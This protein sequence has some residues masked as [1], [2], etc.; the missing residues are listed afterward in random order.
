VRNTLYIRLRA[1][2]P[3]ADTA[4]CI[5]SPQAI[6]SF[7]VRYAPLETIL[8]QAAPYRIVLLVPGAD[9]RFAQ[10]EVPARQAARV[11]QAAPYA[12]EDQLAED[13]DTLHFALGPR[14]QDGRWPV[15]VVARARM[16]EWLQPFLDRGLM[17]EQVVPDVLCLPPA[18]G[19]RW[20][21][22][23]ER[24]HF[25]VRHGS[26]A[27]FSCRPEDL[28]LC[29]Q[30]ADPERQAT[31]RVIVPRDVAADLSHLQR[32]VELLPGFIAPLEALLQNYRAET[33]IN[34]LQG[35][36]S[37]QE[38]LRRLWQPW[39]TSA[40]LL[41]IW[42]GIAAL[43]HGLQGWKMARELAAQEAANVSRYQQIFPA[44][45]RIVDLGVQVDQQFVL[46]KSGGARAGLLN[47]MQV[48]AEAMS[49]APGLTVQSTQ[50]RDGALYVALSGS[51]LQQLESLRSWFATPRAASL[52]VQSANSG[53]EGA[54]IRIR[55]SPA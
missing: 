51:D 27:A 11:L 36:Y 12:L 20:S 8:L 39:R 13:V 50:F 38:D 41:V 48:L 35:A 30:L 53:S 46:L 23:A 10:I 28:E 7:E 17:P 52:E 31:L 43:V 3:G 18:D 4:Y 9:L 15:A 16:D 22:L 6:A 42:L 40:A 44:E 14:Q 5:A 47:L 21:A 54:Q 34:L 25:M 33:S 32:P 45:T 24:D 55:L 26:F 19:E 29:L 37:Q 1:T 2:D 49:A